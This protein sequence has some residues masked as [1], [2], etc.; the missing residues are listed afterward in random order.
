M[1][2]S[3]TKGYYIQESIYYMGRLPFS[4]VILYGIPTPVDGIKEIHWAYASLLS[5]SINPFLFL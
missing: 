4:G 2:V 5:Q 1:A 3:T